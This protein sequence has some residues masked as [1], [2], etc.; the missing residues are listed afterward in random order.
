MTGEDVA[1][2]AAHPTLSSRPREAQRNAIRE[3]AQDS[4]QTQHSFV[5]S[6]H[7]SLDP[8]SSS[9]LKRLVVQG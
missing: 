2:A 3:P 1:T 9:P 4:S 6:A 5:P 8:G 7:I